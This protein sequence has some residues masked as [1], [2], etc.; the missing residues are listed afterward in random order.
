MLKT[1]D[2]CLKSIPKQAKWLSLICLTIIFILAVI[3]LITDCG[4]GAANWI[5]SFI[6]PGSTYSG[7]TLVRYFA[8]LVGL[9][10]MVLG[11][12]LISVITN[13]IQL[14]QK[15]IEDGK[16][17]Y[18]FSNHVIIIGYN[19]MCISLIKQIAEKYPN[20]EIVLQTVQKVPDI[21]YELCANLSP[22]IER[23]VAFVAG[24]RTS[25]EDLEKLHLPKC[26]EIFLLGETEEYDH[27]SQSIKCLE[28]MSD[29]L[30][31][32]QAGNDISLKPCRVL[33]E[34]QSTYAVFQQQDIPN[35]K[36]YLDFLPFNFHECWAQ[37]VLVDS[38][39]EKYPFLDREPITADS[40]KHVHLVVVGMSQMGVAMG[41]QAAHIC[42]F[43]NFVTKGI[44]T[45]ITF[46]DENAEREMHFLQGRYR[47]LFN[48]TDWS[49]WD[50]NTNEQKNNFNSK[51]KFTDLEFEF[52]QGRIE[53]PK[54]RKHLS[55]LTKDNDKLLTIA[56]C[57]SSS[58][59]AIAA[60]LYL[61]DE[62]Y[63][64]NIPVFVRQETSDCTLSL[65]SGG[66][67]K[68]V[69]PFGMLD[70]AYDLKK[71][72][73][74]LPMMVKYA[75]DN[76]NQGKTLEEI[77]KEEI[78]VKNW[79]NNW[80]DAN[81]GKDY[82]NI[83]ALKFS[84]IHNA[85]MI[86]VKSRSLKIEAG[87]ELSY[88]QINLLARIEHNRWNIEKLLMGYRAC[89]LEEKDKIA[90]GKEIE[91]VKPKQ[92]YRDKFVH[93]DIRPYEKLK[94]DDKG[95]QASEYDI[96]ISKALPVMLKKYQK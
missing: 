12:A 54:V 89:T 35:I 66:K 82:K 50:I 63:D 10:G 65:L 64:S 88:E 29:I 84:N 45:K 14:R 7:D 61:P 59:S 27:D 30:K 83:I 67:Y 57:F 96:C 78:L 95:I 47:H 13:I 5:L 87:Q 8:L 76:T 36:E 4:Q 21:R 3:G 15:D 42:H 2:G 70:H 71:A 26:K 44:K 90:E 60:G 40:D 73:S 48:E 1:I 38:D 55:D 74:L 75:Y 17:S 46:I 92:Y 6:N 77:E 32:N 34:Y 80:V 19:K 51:E 53:N 56:V 16:I 94:K 43:P 72:E 93:N 11:G 23:R 69:K 37:K 24:N 39:G 52:I 31:N 62:I 28:E 22:E 25:K 49:F 68:N 18:L 79:K 85:N 91:G 41:I 58:P 33:F 81:T 86:G 9:L 20:C